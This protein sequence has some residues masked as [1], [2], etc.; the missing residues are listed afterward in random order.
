MTEQITTITPNIV[1]GAIDLTDCASLATLI[2]WRAVER[3]AA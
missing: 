2:D 1:D 3:L